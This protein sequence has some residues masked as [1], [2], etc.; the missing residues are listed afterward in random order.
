MGRNE[1]RQSTHLSNI[2]SSQ[3]LQLLEKD[4]VPIPSY[5]YQR[6][7][8][9]HQWR[10][11]ESRQEFAACL[12]ELCR[13]AIEILQNESTLLRLSSPTYVLGDLHGN[14]KDLKFFAQSLWKFS[15]TL[16]PASLLFLGDYVDRG[17]HSVELIAYLLALKINHPEKVFLL[18]G[19]HECKDVNGNVQGY[20]PASF[21]SKCDEFP[22]GIGTAL[23]EAFNACF[24]VMPL[25]AT[26]DNEIFCVHG[27][28]P[29]KTVTSKNILEEIEKI[30]KPC[31][32]ED[33]TNDSNDKYPL[34]YDL[35]WSDPAPS[36]T[37]LEME[38][39][40]VLFVANPRGGNS[41]LFGKEALKEFFRKSGCT[42]IIRAHQPPKLGINIQKGAKLVTVFSS[43]HYCGGYNSAAGVLVADHRLRIMIVNPTL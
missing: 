40:K 36:D 15:V 25:A 34:S 21:Y 9:S 20:G 17:P 37:E 11:E 12:I 33:L 42:H 13:E 7:T 5:N 6:S 39:K 30:K 3:I 10:S 8:S 14:Y 35:L 2:C 4:F 43:S 32:L 31:T 29:R 16:C 38:A 1:L 26:I 19:N 22:N 27:G 41:C 23:W 24:D 18:R 28:V